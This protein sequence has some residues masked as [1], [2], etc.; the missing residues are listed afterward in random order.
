MA[1][2]DTWRLPP[3]VSRAVAEA[4]TAK[5]GPRNVWM[6]AWYWHQPSFSA[7]LKV[8]FLVLVSA[9]NSALNYWKWG[10]S[11]AGP[12]V[13]DRVGQFKEHVDGGFEDV[14]HLDKNC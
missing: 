13:N 7:S 4:K 3:M 12:P 1:I 2:I 11:Q 6:I 9:L 10:S 5:T 8:G 14:V